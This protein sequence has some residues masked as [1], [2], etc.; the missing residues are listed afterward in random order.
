M[1][2][3]LAPESR[4]RTFWWFLSNL[5]NPLLAP[6]G[7][8]RAIWRFLLGLLLVFLANS[9]AVGL[10]LRFVAPDA[11]AFEFIYRPTA[12]IFLLVGFSV[13]LIIFD[14][15]SRPLPAM[16]LGRPW[17][18]A[19]VLGLLIGAGMVVIAVACVAV[20][21]DLRFAATLN[22]RVLA[23]ILITIFILATAAMAEELAFRGYPFQRLVESLGTWAAVVLMSV[24]FGLVHL[25][26]PHASPFSTLNT[27]LLGMLLCVAYLRTGALWVPFGI[28]LGWNAT[29]GLVLGLPVSGLT[30]FAVMV[31]GMTA[32]PLWLTGGSYG[33]E[34]SLI[35]TFTVVL[36]FLALIAFVPS[37]PR[38]FP[39]RFVPQ[40][41]PEVAQGPGLVI[42]EP[43]SEPGATRP[44][45]GEAAGVG[46]AQP[47]AEPF[48]ESSETSSAAQPEIRSPEPKEDHSK[49]Q[50]RP[51]D[52]L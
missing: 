46:G 23:R 38:P 39:Q 6:D 36:G 37:T 35:C 43:W 20:A 19:T 31:R 44:E 21:G 45:S 52:D 12:M 41:V 33:I 13:F 30:Q 11:R 27:I 16:G 34:G 17:R 3:L 5:P 9:F 24:P 50:P 7:R 14:R 10:A 51:G 42:S 32:G 1:N 25:G 48:P 47:V 26:N 40:F 2:P 22:R 49:E 29:L 28:H 18:R 15:A 8:L 4:L